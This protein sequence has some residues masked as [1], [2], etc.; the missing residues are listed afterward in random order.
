MSEDLGT[1]TN[2]YTITFNRR[3]KHSPARLWR[4]LT[5]PEEVAGWTDA[6]ATIDLRVGG[7]YTFFVGT[8]TPEECIVVRAEPER[9]LT[10]VWGMNRP[11]AWRHAS[12]VEWTI[13]DD[14]EGCSFTFV[15]NGC[16]DRGEGEAGLAAGWHGFLDQLG[17]H[18]DGKT[19]TK[20]EAEADWK[21]LH[22][23]YDA[24]LNTALV[25]RS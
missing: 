6:P 23:P 15:H 5:D 18:L 14:E 12:V 2:C 4:A 10:I 11:E 16:A 3:S 17:K 19:W 13:S 21:R 1:I 25:N 24:R 22:E 7:T 9:V 20:E 8:E